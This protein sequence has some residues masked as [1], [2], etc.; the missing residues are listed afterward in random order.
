LAHFARGPAD[1]EAL[2]T[3]RAKRSKLSSDLCSIDNISFYMRG[4]L[5]IRIK[6]PVPDTSVTTT[7]SS[8][9]S[10]PPSSS[11]IDAA[12]PDVLFTWGVWI[13]VATQHFYA[14]MEGWSSKKQATY[15]GTLNT[16]LPMYP[17]TSDMKVELVLLNNGQRPTVRLL[18]RE[19]ELTKD[20]QDGM[21]L[22]RF[23]TLV[24]SLVHPDRRSS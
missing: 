21:S 3:D 1:W 10:P 7:T 15:P 12:P 17:S 14:I 9:A 18:E 16:R 24:P 23:E 19:H 13:K 11:S 6:V 22:S 8:S 20:W 2:T 5:Q 4:L